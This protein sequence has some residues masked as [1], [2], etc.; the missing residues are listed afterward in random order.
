MGAVS[1]PEGRQPT[2]AAILI[3]L[4]RLSASHREAL[5]ALGTNLGQKSRFSPRFPLQAWTCF[6]IGSK[7]R[8]MR[9]ILILATSTRRRCFVCFASTG[10][11]APETM[12]ASL[13]FKLFGWRADRFWP[14]PLLS[15][16]RCLDQPVH[17]TFFGPK[18][19]SPRGG[20]PFNVVA[21]EEQTRFEFKERSA[22]LLWHLLCDSTI[23]R[24]LEIYCVL[25]RENLHL[26]LGFGLC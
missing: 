17:C 20:R 22:E 25:G 12:L 13:K 11:N 6:F 1:Q 23:V 2:L 7:F 24:G 18:D 16:F 8:W 5:P 10:M 26:L 3:D 9:S 19:S 4:Q 14:R 21:P 15:V